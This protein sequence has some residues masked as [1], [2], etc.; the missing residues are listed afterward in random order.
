MQI[1]EETYFVFK[2]REMQKNFTNFILMVI[3]KINDIKKTFWAIKKASG[4]MEKKMPKT[5]ADRMNDTKLL[6]MGMQKNID[7]LAEIGLTEEKVSAL[8]ELQKRAS[9]LNTKQESLKKQLK[10][11]TAEL[12]EATK[13]LNVKQSD[14]RKRIKIVIP[15]NEWK[16][17]GIDSKK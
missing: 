13:E 15:Q 14:F 10:E 9:E 6:V 16:E 4:T 5:F 17:F 7:R 12:T 1:F 3:M 8:E 2:I 11:C